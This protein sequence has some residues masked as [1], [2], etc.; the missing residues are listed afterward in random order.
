M[1]VSF[2][3]EV[4]FCILAT[5]LGQKIFGESLR[6]M[7]VIPRAWQNWEMHYFEGYL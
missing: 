6:E 2:G 7:V 3:I 1:F 5:K 4:T